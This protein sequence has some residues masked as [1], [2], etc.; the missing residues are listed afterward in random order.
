VDQHPRC[1]SVLG[2][3]NAAIHLWRVSPGPVVGSTR[4]VPLRHVHPP[5][6][7]FT[8]ADPR[9][10]VV[11]FDRGRILRGLVHLPFSTD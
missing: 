5:L 7:G 1:G 8:M 3:V 10:G 11:G 9:L 4:V 6:F 2:M